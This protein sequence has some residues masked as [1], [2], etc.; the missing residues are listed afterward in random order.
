MSAT[1]MPLK[2]TRSVRP[3]SLFRPAL[4]VL[5]WTAADEAVIESSRWS[6]CITVAG[7]LVRSLVENRRAVGGELQRSEE[8]TS[9]LQSPVHLVCRLLLEKKNTTQSSI[10]FGHICLF[11]NV[12]GALP[13]P[14]RFS[15]TFSPLDLV[16]AGSAATTTCASVRR[17]DTVPGT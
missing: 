13:P 6:A 7:P 14:R 12:V 1:A 4:R 16:T 2:N 10:G 5:R 9:E 15:G 3:A 8:H 11:F 17:V